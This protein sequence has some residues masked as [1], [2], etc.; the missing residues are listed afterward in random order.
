MKFRKGINKLRFYSSF[1]LLGFYMTVGFIFLFT[2]VWADLVPK[3]R[4]LI[5][6]LLIVFGALRF[7][8]AYRRY[9]NK[10]LVFKTKDEEDTSSE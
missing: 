10:N 2:E 7:Y 4:Y 1:L 6:I 5:G 9:I 3:G 8:V